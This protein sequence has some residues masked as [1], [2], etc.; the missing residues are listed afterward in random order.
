VQQIQNIMARAEREG[1]ALS[2]EDRRELRRLT[3]RDN[4]SS[5]FVRNAEE[6]TLQ[7]A[8]LK[9]LCRLMVRDRHPYCALNG[10]LMLIPFAGTDS[11]QD[12]TDTGDLCHRDLT[13]AR[14]T[15]KVYCPVIALLCDAETAPGF[16][17]F[18]ARFNAK[19]RLQRI[20]QRCPLLPD[21]KERTGRG[22]VPSSDDPLGDMLSSMMRWI[23][24]SVVPGW[25]Y[26]KFRLEKGGEEDVSGL[27]RD[28]ARLFLFFD[29]LSDRQRRL[30][31]ILRRALEMEDRSSPLLFGGCYLAGTGTD[32]AREQAFVAGVF[33]RLME[34]ESS[35]YWTEQTLM[36]EAL[37]LRW[38][39]IGWLVLLLVG[40][41]GLALLVYMLANGGPLLAR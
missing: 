11:E 12:A 39:G 5:S 28:N 8:R 36:E 40:A 24:K 6:I 10:I 41:A 30:A 25:A 2:K 15:L 33:K 4:P 26:K 20:G 23:C 31:T 34:S 21:L 14:A 37:Y 18:V 17:E 13:V 16:A 35:V 27:T 9:H 7:T 38:I 29:D 32:A 1:R 19:E 3:R 22:G